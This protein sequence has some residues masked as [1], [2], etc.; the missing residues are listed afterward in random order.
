MKITTYECD[1]CG[2]VKQKSNHWFTYNATSGFV[3]VHIY[4]WHQ[5]HVDLE[6]VK[7][8]CGIGCVTKK[9][10]ELLQPQKQEAVSEAGGYRQL[11]LTPLQRSVNIF[12][13]K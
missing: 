2:T 12:E 8:L 9:V 3:G 7:H 5:K 11:D 1:V 4:Q 6:G 13:Q 10:N